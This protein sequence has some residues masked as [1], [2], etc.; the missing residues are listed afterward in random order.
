MYVWSWLFDSHVFLWKVGQRILESRNL[1]GKPLIATK[2]SCAKLPG[3][4]CVPQPRHGHGKSIVNGALVGPAI[5][6]C[7][8]GLMK[9]DTG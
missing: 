1:G 3:T 5:A 7:P 4:H 8:D 2:Q 9:S 6:C